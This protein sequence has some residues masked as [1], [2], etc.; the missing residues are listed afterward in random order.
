MEWTQRTRMAVCLG[1]SVL[2]H[3]FVIFG[4]II[5][6]PAAKN[7]G[8]RTF[9]AQL[10]TGA[11]AA[12]PLNIVEPQSVEESLES[13]LPAPRAQPPQ[14]RPVPASAPE[15]PAAAPVALHAQSAG[16]A[17]VP[18][19]VLPQIESRSAIDDTWY[20]AK[21][22]DV[23]PVA[24]VEV[25]PRYPDQAAAQS[26]GGEV[27]LLLLVDEMGEVHERT[28]VEA[29][30]PGVFDAAVLEAFRKVHFEPARKDGRRVRSRVLVTVT[31]DPRSI[32]REDAFS[33]PEATQ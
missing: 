30:P 22:L 17:E 11:Q 33:A 29:D 26:V 20:P 7:I 10:E 8:P 16:A 19:S 25:E 32:E 4:L 28:V 2:A 18:A 1:V 12:V 3:G 9:E 31:F 15:A 14:R 21:Q 24:Q 6:P 13:V 27:T 23:L 5:R